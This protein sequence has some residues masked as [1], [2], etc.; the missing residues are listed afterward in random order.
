[1]LDE[2]S[3]HFDLL[4]SA[5][6]VLIVAGAGFL[7]NQ[8]REKREFTQTLLGRV[9][10]DEHLA[11]ADFL[12]HQYMVDCHKKGMPTCCTGISAD[13]LPA[14]LQEAI[15]MTMN[16][17]QQIAI[18][19]QSGILDHHFVLQVWGVHI[20]RTVTFFLDYIEEMR[21]DSDRPALYAELEAFAL[22]AAAAYDDR[23]QNT[24]RR[25][26]V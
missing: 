2:V 20:H 1:M 14:E 11:R 24:R 8:R 23:H 9:L 5:I 21:R 18:S 26:A 25:P 6:V 22:G 4:I 17:Y 16:Y 10:S 7:T 15:R 12:I 13:D 3:G 19:C